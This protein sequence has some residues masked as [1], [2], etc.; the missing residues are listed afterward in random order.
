[1]IVRQAGKADL[2]AILNLEAQGMAAPWSAG[3]LESEFTH[4]AGLM[5]L[6]EEGGLVAGYIS[7]RAGTFEVELMRLVVLPPW[8]RQGIAGRL[9]RTGLDRFAGQG[10][11]FCLLEVRAANSSARSLYAEIGFAVIGTRLKYYR[12]PQDDAVLMQYTMTGSQERG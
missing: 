7:F 11:E 1:M 6:A 2:A 3:Q 9:L 8:R 4:Q 10:L 5:L 12:Q